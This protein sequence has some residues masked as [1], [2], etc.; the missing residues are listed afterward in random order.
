[1]KDVFETG[2]L[3]PSPAS[4]P[5]ETISEKDLDQDSIHL[6]EMVADKVRRP[7]AEAEGRG[8]LGQRAEEVI[9]VSPPRTRK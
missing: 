6:F 7:G 3:P 2:S 9:A 4:L 5:Q 1:M 8:L